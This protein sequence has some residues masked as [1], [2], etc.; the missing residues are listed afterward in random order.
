MQSHVLPSMRLLCQVKPPR[1]DYNIME[2]FNSE[3]GKSFSIARCVI[4]KSILLNV[5]ASAA[6]QSHY[7]LVGDCFVK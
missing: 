6:K 2:F 7:H 3:I 1:N 5:I 4:R